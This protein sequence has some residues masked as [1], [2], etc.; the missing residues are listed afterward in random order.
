MSC[1]D[2]EGIVEAKRKGKSIEEIAHSFMITKDFVRKILREEGIEMEASEEGVFHTRISQKPYRHGTIIDG[3]AI[4]NADMKQ[5]VEEAKHALGA[6]IQKPDKNDYEFTIPFQH[7]QYT[8][9]VRR[10]EAFVRWFGQH[11]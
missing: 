4:S 8:K 1:V 2:V 9:D 7:A 6:F 10:Y 3:N 5:I 11:T